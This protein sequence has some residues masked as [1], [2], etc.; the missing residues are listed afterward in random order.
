MQTIENILLDLQKNT[1]N[2][3]LD[4]KSNVESKINNVKESINNIQEYYADEIIKKISYKK[5]HLIKNNEEYI[6]SKKTLKKLDFLFTPF[7]ILICFGMFSSLLFLLLDNDKALNIGSM[8][9]ITLILGMIPAHFCDKLNKKMLYKIRENI[10][11]DDTDFKRM[12]KEITL[13]TIEKISNITE[14]D[15][16]IKNSLIEYLVQEN[17]SLESNKESV[18]GFIK[19][20]IAYKINKNDFDSLENKKVLITDVNIKEETILINETLSFEEQLNFLINHKR[21]Q[22]NI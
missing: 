8:T 7:L 11:N 17:Y 18:L 21:E 22:E 3:K 16:N 14:Y 6:K 1:I 10:F 9:F 13:D 12:I 20:K 15:K 4:T 19:N 2:L 5:I